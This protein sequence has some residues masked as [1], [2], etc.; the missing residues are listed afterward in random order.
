M[1][2][3]INRLTAAL[4]VLNA[5]EEGEFGLISSADA[6]KIGYDID[7]EEAAWLDWADG[8]AIGN[9]ATGLIEVAIPAGTFVDSFF[10]DPITGEISSI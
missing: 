6:F 5:Y 10:L 2:I 4:H 9:V 8:V 1:G 3:A 7:A